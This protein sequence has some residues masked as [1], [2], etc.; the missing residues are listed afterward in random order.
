MKKSSYILYTYISI[1]I[2]Y[3]KMNEYAIILLK[4]SMKKIEFY[5]PMTPRSECAPQNPRP[6]DRSPLR[7][8]H[9][10]D[11]NIPAAGE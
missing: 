9:R 5:R 11:A 1:Y 8:G 6:R 10:R 4:K 2:I 3:K 7:R